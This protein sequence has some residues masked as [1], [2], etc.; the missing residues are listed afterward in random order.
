MLLLLGH[1]QLQG[2]ASLIEQLRCTGPILDCA[3]LGV[4]LWDR[5][6]ILDLGSWRL[7][8]ARVA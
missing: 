8:L 5:G 6:F 7:N 1:L 2:L 3:T 4:G